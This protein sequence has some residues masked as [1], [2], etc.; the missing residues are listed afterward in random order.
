MKQINSNK[1]ILIVWCPQFS[2]YNLVVRI[3]EIA[4]EM[5]YDH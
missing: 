4:L 5:K 3:V 2:K 1:T